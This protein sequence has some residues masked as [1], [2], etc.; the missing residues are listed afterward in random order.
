M[1]F[2][3]EGGMLLNPAL[4][5]MNCIYPGDGNSM[6]FTGDSQESPGCGGDQCQNV[7]RDWNCNFPPSLL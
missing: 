2:T 6:A 3:N 5:R 7:Y 4:V 1:Y